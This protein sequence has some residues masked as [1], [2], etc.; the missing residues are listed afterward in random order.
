MKLIQN[1]VQPFTV[2]TILYEKDGFTIA[3]GKWGEEP[4]R[5][6]M[7]WHKDL[8]SDVPSNQLDQEWFHLPCDSK[9]TIEILKS[10]F[11]I[12]SAFK[13]TE[14]VKTAF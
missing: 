1:E 7:K 9:F 13:D 3:Y 10:I 8:L 12:R 14:S 5:L 6:A 2:H 4:A 11:E